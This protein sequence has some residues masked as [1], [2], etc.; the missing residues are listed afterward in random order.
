[1]K[2]EPASVDQAANSNSSS[3]T[4]RNN[5]LYKIKETD[6][7]SCLAK[8]G[9]MIQ[10]REKSNYEQYTAFYENLLRQQHQLLYNKEIEIKQLDHL[11]QNKTAQIN[12]EAQ[13]RMADLCYD[14]II[15]NL[16]CDVLYFCFWIKKKRK[17]INSS[18]CS[19]LEVT[20]LRGKLNET[21]LSK[22]SLEKEM[23]QKIKAQYVDLV[24][25]LLKVNTSLK[26]QIDYFKYI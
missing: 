24:A 7:K 22:D 3:S 14:L 4:E 21:N 9:I 26:S 6:L 5:I 12:A 16:I 10:E 15:G 19:W 13:C 8:L 18:N 25:D 23:K 2:A 1:M 11:F 20:A 17:I